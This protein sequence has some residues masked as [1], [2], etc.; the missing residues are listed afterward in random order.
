[1]AGLRSHFVR[2]FHKGLL[3]EESGAENGVFVYTN[4]FNSR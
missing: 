2:V 4:M 1:M 3:H